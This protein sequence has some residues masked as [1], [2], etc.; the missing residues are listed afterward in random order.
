ML[1]R[2]FANLE[3]VLELEEDAVSLCCVSNSANVAL[4]QVQL[5]RI[6]VFPFQAQ[7][8]FLKVLNY[9]SNVLRLEQLKVLLAQVFCVLQ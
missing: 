9:V 5:P 4:S 1:F 8:N 7:T 3:N 6:K 2:D